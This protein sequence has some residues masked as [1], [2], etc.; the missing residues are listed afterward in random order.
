VT[1]SH[2]VTLSGAEFVAGTSYN[3]IAELNAKNVN[4]ENE[5]EPIVFAVNEVETWVDASDDVTV[6]SGSDDSDEDDDT[7]NEDGQN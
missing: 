6:V 4:P 2:E 1:Y 3:L 7:E 5:I